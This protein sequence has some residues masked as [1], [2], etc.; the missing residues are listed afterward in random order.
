MA[1]ACQS[2]RI[3]TTI[4]PLPRATHWVQ[5]GS[6]KTSI[7][8]DDNLVKELNRAVLLIGE[9][10][11]TVLRL[12]IRAGLPVIEGRFQSPRPEG[13]FQHVY[14]DEERAEFENSLGK[15]PKQGLDR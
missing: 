5:N 10:S 3:V 7:D 4:W 8:L 2:C 6:V 13:Y 14:E 9:K 1:M 15:G 11:A 12:A